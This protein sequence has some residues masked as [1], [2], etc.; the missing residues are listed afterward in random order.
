MLDLIVFIVT[1][2]ITPGPN[3]IASLANAS[4]KGIRKGIFLNLGMFVG[5]LLLSSLS[6]MLSFIIFRVLPQI[7]PA[8]QLLGALY[9]LY[10]AIMLL[11]KN[12]IS[13]A[14]DTGG[15]KTGVVMQLANMKVMLLCLSAISSFII[16][17]SKSWLE[18]YILSLLIPIICF[19]TGLLWALCGQILSNAY[20]QHTRLFNIVFASSLII[21]AIK[22][23]LRAFA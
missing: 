5:I 2:S 3:T 17:I 23:T 4:R 7:E 8:M 20:K 13:L 1:M 10:L 11:A 16:P 6:Y 19:L 14:K 18:G 9:M 22:C 21:L 15:F 12:N